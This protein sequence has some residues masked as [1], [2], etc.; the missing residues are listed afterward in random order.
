MWH[1]NPNRLWWAVLRSRHAF[2]PFFFSIK[3]NSAFYNKVTNSSWQKIV[4]C[5]WNLIEGQLLSMVF[6]QG[7][8]LLRSSISSFIRYQR[9]TLFPVFI[10]LLKNLR[11]FPGSKLE[12]FFLGVDFKCSKVIKKYTAGFLRIEISG[13]FERQNFNYQLDRLDKLQQL[14]PLRFSSPLCISSSYWPTWPIVF[15]GTLPCYYPKIYLRWKS[16]VF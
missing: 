9:S 5:F 14:F 16:F 7:E 2:I 8:P 4:R 12:D 15:F 1:L 13:R 3:K 10:W 6:I 11:K